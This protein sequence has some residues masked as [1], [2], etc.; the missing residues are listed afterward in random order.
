MSGQGW[1]AKAEEF[2]IPS[3]V[4]CIG[5][6]AC[7]RN[8]TSRFRK[9]FHNPLSSGSH[10][11]IANHALHP[12]SSSLDRSLSLSAIS[13]GCDLLASEFDFS[14]VVIHCTIIYLYIEVLCRLRIFRPL[15]HSIYYPICDQYFK[16]S[17]QAYTTL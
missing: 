6:C 14:T 11:F 17:F 9:H 3:H 13:T 5:P 7:C 2:T 4:Y 12:H 1:P 8:G 10:F 16:F 15:H